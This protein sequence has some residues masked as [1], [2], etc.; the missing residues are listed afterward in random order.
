MLL[1]ALPLAATFKYPKFL[2]LSSSV[3]PSMFMQALHYLTASHG[4]RHA[5][6]PLHG[7]LYGLKQMLAPLP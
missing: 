3:L 2:W 7:L 6:L 4:D 5:D 1:E